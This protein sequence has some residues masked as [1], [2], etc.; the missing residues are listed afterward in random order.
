MRWMLADLLDDLRDLAGDTEDSRTWK[1]EVLSVRAEVPVPPSNAS[2]GPT[3]VL[4]MRI[5]LRVDLSPVH[6]ASASDAE[7][8]HGME[9]RARSAGAVAQRLAASMRGQRPGSEGGT[10][11]LTV[12]P[13]SVAV[14]V[15]LPC[16][17]A[18]RQQH[19]ETCEAEWSEYFGW[20][21]VWPQL[22]LACMSLASG[23][24]V[25]CG[26]IDVKANG[27]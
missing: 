14:E 10:W 23:F 19:A 11:L 21:S 3:P 8:L 16:L 9:Q 15:Q 1:V 5:S 26:S 18:M 27:W 24:G 22:A 25:C 7:S 4:P 6:L 12:D 20:G 13:D 2:C 17:R